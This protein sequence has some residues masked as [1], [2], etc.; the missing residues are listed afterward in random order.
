M[1]ERTVLQWLNRNPDAVQ[2]ESFVALTQVGLVLLRT[3][4]FVGGLAAAFLDNTI[5]GKK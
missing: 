3:P 1:L 2:V 4:M 5:P